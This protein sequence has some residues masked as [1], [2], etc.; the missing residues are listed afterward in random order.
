MSE[1]YTKI[2]RGKLIIENSYPNPI[3]VVFRRYIHSDPDDLTGRLQSLINLSEVFVKFL[4]IVQLQEGR[5]YIPDFKDKLPDG[6]KTLEF[7][8]HPSFG[9]WAGLLRTLSKANLTN[10]E[11]F[12]IP[13]I[14]EWYKQKKNNEIS[15]AVKNLREY[16]GNKTN[17]IS[18]NPIAEICDILP[19]I[20]N[21]SFAHGARLTKEV[22][23][24]KL[25]L[26][27]DS[28]TILLKSASFLEE[29]L[30]FYVDKVEKAKNNKWL[31]HAKKLEGAFDVPVRYSYQ[32]ELELEEVYLSKKVENELEEN[33]ITLTPFLLWRVNE[34]EKN[35][36]M[37]F[38]EDILP[39]KLEYLS[40]AS[41][42]YYLHQELHSAFSDLI[43]LKVEPGNEQNKQLS[44][45]EDE[46]IERAENL[47]NRALIFLQQGRFQNALDYLEQA[48]FYQ[49]RAD[50]FLKMAEVMSELE[51]HPKEIKQLLQKC[52]EIEPENLRAQ[53]LLSQ[54]VENDERIDFQ[55]EGGES[56]KLNN[57]TNYVERKS[58]QGIHPEDEIQLNKFNVFHLFCPQILVKFAALFW[59]LLICGWYS[60]SAIIE[61]S[62]GHT[63]QTIAILLQLLCCLAIIFAAIT[64]R[65]WVENL[66]YPLKAQVD[67]KE[68]SR[69]D[70]WF[71]RQ[72][73]L[74]F[75]TFC[76]DNQ[77]IQII[78]SIKREKWLYIGAVVW[79]V[80]MSTA[81]LFFTLSYKIS[82]ILL[83]KRF[84]DYAIIF[85]FLY[86]GARYTIAITIFV[87]RF[88]KLSLKPMLTK[89]NIDGVRSLGPFIAFNIVLA[90]FIYFILHL[91]FA[92]T[93]TNPF[94]GD[95]FFLC[96]G[97]SIIAVWTIA[98]PYQLRRALQSAKS[99]VVYEYSNHIESA[100][101]AFLDNPD[102]EN[103]KLYQR[104][105]EKQKIIKNIP[106]WALSVSETLFVVV[107]GNLLLI[108]A[109]TAYV[110]NRLG[111][112]SM[113]TQ[114]FT[115]Q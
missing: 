54:L 48:L 16:Q 42:D 89:I 104:I 67:S 77:R 52:L 115:A 30:V 111:L 68:K 85:A 69:F 108:L 88:S 46:R 13:K 101:K 91:S 84:V 92:L 65:S 50:I 76:I 106:V 21:D 83:I 8:R 41:G 78:P 5:K 60:T 100:F 72:I 107:G 33:I 109:A 25:H 37:Y 19:N 58:L 93:Y 80:V 10:S 53:S 73:V 35:Y 79:I 113:I 75:G 56:E 47:Y 114:Y 38:Y 40:Y 66:R 11:T 1:S 64:I 22:I 87:Y 34:A 112:W 98:F 63:L 96:I 24:K 103:E 99:T 74:I 20:R 51:D 3:A 27:E 15:L 4:C 36:E 102:D 55:F 43:N 45:T 29:M 7:L 12:W 17:S 86:A 71:D 26:L 28:L 62:V 95:L 94:L 14:T 81:A 9:H 105:L 61:L 39:T 70:K 49:R 90:T 57:Q 82:T 44:I 23:I 110:I 31:I 59:S 2:D 6:A 18:K 32:N 97:T